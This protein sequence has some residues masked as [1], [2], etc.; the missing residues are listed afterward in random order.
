MSGPPGLSGEVPGAGVDAD[1]AVA[2]RVGRDRG[3]RPGPGRHRSGGAG[4]GHFDLDDQP[5][6]Q[7]TTV[8]SPYAAGTRAAARWGPEADDRQGSHAAA[9]SGGA[10]RADDLRG[11]GLP[12]ALDREEHPDPGADP[13]EHGPPRQPPTGAG[14]PRRRRV[15]L[16]SQPQNA[17]RPTAPRPGRSVPPHHRTGP[18]DTRRAASSPMSNS[19][20]S[21]SRPIGFTRTGTT[22]SIR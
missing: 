8:A 13:A 18:P 3:A 21:G 11:P 19:P 20:P 16:A 1:G 15:Q 9:R 7:R 4:H 14:A 12:P 6:A 2:P 10:G 5:R 17:R 22:P